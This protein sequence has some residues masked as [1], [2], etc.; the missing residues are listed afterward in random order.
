MTHHRIAPPG[1]GGRSGCWLHRRGDGWHSARH[2][3][4][5][6]P[7]LPPLG[8]LGVVADGVMGL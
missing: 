4:R 5:D 7:L 3:L 6:A 2:G 8:G 1:P